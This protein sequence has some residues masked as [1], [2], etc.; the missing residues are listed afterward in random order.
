MN[1]PASRSTIAWLLFISDIIGLLFCFHLAFILRLR[2]LLNWNSPSLYGLIIV[3]LLG[4]YLADTYKL[5]RKVSSLWT[6]DRVLFGI[7]A[8][9]GVITSGIYLT[10]LWGRDPLLGR[11]VLFLSV[12][13]F[14]VWAVFWRLA[15]NQWVKIKEEHTRFLVL[16]QEDKAIDFG[17]QYYS[18]Y[19]KSEFV[20]L[21]RSK[22]MLSLVGANGYSQEINTTQPIFPLDNYLSIDSIDNFTTWS[23]QSW[24]GVLIDDTEQELSEEMVRELM[25]MRLRGIYVYSLAD[26]CEQ[27]WHKIPPSY[28]Q[29]DWF[30]FTSGFSIL[31]NRIDAKLK[32]VVDFLAAALLLTVTFPLTLLVAIAIKIDSPGP[33]FYSQVRT[34][35]N[36]KKFKVYKFR[37]MYENAEQM[38]VQWAQEKDPRITKI[39]RW[40]RL[41]RIDEL[42]QLWNIL[43]GDMSLVGPRPERPE[44][45]AQLRKEIPY[46]D[47]RYLVKPGITGWAQVC[48]PYGASIEDAYQKVAYDLY[49]IKNYSLLLDA[50]I[51]LKTIRVV[52]LGKGR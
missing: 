44:F 33:I 3:Y 41:A 48:Y 37:S 46:Y 14:T 52:L 39:G 21:T 42:P 10:G 36:G 4:L 9:V 6:S 16:G 5:G 22:Q 23:K 29:D 12:G 1:N 24:S 32:Q 2:Q 45:D 25:D 35:L 7:L 51:A 18:T 15:T 27:F 50:A 31:H 49:Y 30:A 28:I 40:L 8:T 43:K 47:V 11:G 34:G 20:F 19:D 26:F 13:L 38:G 17:R